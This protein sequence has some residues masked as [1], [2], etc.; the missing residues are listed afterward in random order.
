M[1][2]GDNMARGRKKSIQELEREHERAKARA[3]AIKARI[4]YEKKKAMIK[5]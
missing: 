3:E 2:G 5:R 4:E 1:K